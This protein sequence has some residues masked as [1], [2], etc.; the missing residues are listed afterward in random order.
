MPVP[1]CPSTIYQEVNLSNNLLSELPPLWESLWGCVDPATGLLALTLVAPVKQ[2]RGVEKEKGK[3]V[4]KVLLLGNPIMTITATSTSS[5][6]T[7]AS[8]GKA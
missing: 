6:N 4:A 5:S 7:T 1:V 2:D 8:A 3:E